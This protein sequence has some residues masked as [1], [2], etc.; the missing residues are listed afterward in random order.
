MSATNGVNFNDISDEMLENQV[1]YQFKF[2]T[3]AIDGTS[4]ETYSIYRR[5]GNLD[6]VFDNIRKLNKYKEK[7]NSIFPLL[8]WQYIVFE[9]NKHEI[10]NIKEL[11]KELG[12]K[13]LSFQES[14]SREVK[15]SDIIKK[16]HIL[17]D[18]TEEIRN[19]FKEESIG[20]MCGQLW[21]SPQINWDGTLL[22]CCCST[23][24]SLETNVF[25]E[26]LK[27]SLKSRK[28]KLMRKI[29]TGKET[30]DE[31]ISCYSCH[32]YN[33]FKEKNS[34]FNPKKLRFN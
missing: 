26:G 22:G 6:K 20:S 16:S 29:I 7:Y 4:N 24:N 3:I 10:C 5:N 8:T 28:S 25:K 1:K 9:H 19:I 33:N 15:L 2:I 32:I 34:F 18:C 12:F 11:A 14:W 17:I 27:K 31:T 13:R 21:L 23:Y 30:P